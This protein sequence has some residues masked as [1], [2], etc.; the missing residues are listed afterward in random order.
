MRF[1]QVQDNSVGFWDSSCEKHPEKTNSQG[2]LGIRA[3]VSYANAEAQKLV[4]T[5]G[6]V[7]LDVRDRTQYERAHITSCDHVP[8]LFKTTTM[9]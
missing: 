1:Q 4:E 9:I 7:V 5:Q 2:K 8:F 3:E 6:Y